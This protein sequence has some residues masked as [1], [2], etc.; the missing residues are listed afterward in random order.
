MS[1]DAVA[2]PVHRHQVTKGD[3]D[4][5]RLVI[6]FWDHCFPTKTNVNDMP[7]EAML[8]FAYNSH[9]LVDLKHVLSVMMECLG[10][11]GQVLSG[12]SCYEGGDVF[13]SGSIDEACWGKLL[14][15]EPRLVCVAVELVF[16]IGHTLHCRHTPSVLQFTCR[17]CSGRGSAS[18]LSF[19]CLCNLLEYARQEGNDHRCL[20]VRVLPTDNP[21]IVTIT[22][23]LTTHPRA[24]LE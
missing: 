14:H 24:N 1:L 2:Y 19:C 12:R 22:A 11:R 6:A 17:P 20:S 13:G 21:C 5:R 4:G 23:V 3:K 16:V 10:E 18:L 7:Y 8:L 9:V 15:N